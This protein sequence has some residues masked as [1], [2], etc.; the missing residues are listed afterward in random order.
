MSE[1][2]YC[3]FC[4]CQRLGV[5]L[6]CVSF[7]RAA[8]R[9]ALLCRVAKL[10]KKQGSYH[11]ATK[12]YTQAGEKLKAMK[13]LLRSGDTEKIIFFAGVSRHRDIYI[14][15]ANYLQNLDWHND[16]EIMKNI[17]SFYTK[18]RAYEQLSNF[19]ES[20]AALEIDEYRNYEKVCQFLLHFGWFPWGM[21]ICDGLLACLS[22]VLSVE[23]W[24]SIHIAARLW[25]LL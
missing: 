15:A 3:L 2:S 22:V 14:L 18:A 8:A 10:C 21:S 24:C 13:S 9:N 7:P 16:A 5:L 1:L 6:H 19:Y 11:L 4:F 20:C 25:C 17:I 23:C 12:K